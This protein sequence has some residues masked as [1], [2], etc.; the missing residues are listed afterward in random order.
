MTMIRRYWRDSPA[1]AF[2]TAFEFGIDLTGIL[3]CEERK[4]DKIRM[5]ARGIAQSRK[6]GMP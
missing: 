1:Y 3:L 6:Q 4:W 2:W 5:I